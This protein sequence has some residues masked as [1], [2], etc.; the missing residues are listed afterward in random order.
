MNIKIALEMRFVIQPLGAP[1][2]AD[3]DSD[4]WQVHSNDVVQQHSS[5]LLPIAKSHSL[6]LPRNRQMHANVTRKAPARQQ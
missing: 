6:V 2:W 3:N 5:L 4:V 1:G